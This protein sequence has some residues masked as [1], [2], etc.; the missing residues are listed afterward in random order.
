MRLTTMSA[1]TPKSVHRVLGSQELMRKSVFAWV[2]RRAPG[3]SR[4][5][6]CASHLQ[7]ISMRRGIQAPIMELTLDTTLEQ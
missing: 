3:A 7:T 6:G 5:L 1:R 2:R 4:F